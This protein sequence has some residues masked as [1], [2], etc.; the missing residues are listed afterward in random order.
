MTNQITQAEQVTQP[1]NCFDC[2]TSPEHMH[3]TWAQMSDICKH[4]D[5]LHEITINDPQ[6]ED[7]E[8]DETVMDWHELMSQYDDAGGRQ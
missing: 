1:V 3:L 6:A 5:V 2:L 7:A 4:C 8:I